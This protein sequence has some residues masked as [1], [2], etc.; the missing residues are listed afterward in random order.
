MICNFESQSEC[1]EASS[2]MRVSKSSAFMKPII[3]ALSCSFAVMLSTSA[4]LAM[5]WEGHDDW[6]DS[7]SHGIKLRNHLPKP[8]DR[9]YPSCDEMRALSKDNPYEQRPLPGKNCLDQDAIDDEPSTDGM[10]IK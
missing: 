6:L 5:N 7:Q 4:S 2:R 1:R 8:L 9:T 3:H 10:P